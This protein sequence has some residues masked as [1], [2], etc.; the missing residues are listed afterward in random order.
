MRKVQASLESPRADAAIRAFLDLD[1]LR[2]WWGVE[3][4]LVEPRPGGLWAVSW[5]KNTYV[6]TGRIEVLE[7]ARLVIGNYVYFNPE[8]PVLGPMTLT[9]AS[10]GKEATVTQDGYRDGPDWDWYYES[11]RVAWPQVMPSLKAWLERA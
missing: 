7:P 6:S 9:V 8:R 11:V 4:A 1:A 10:S 2:G 5:Q 3:K